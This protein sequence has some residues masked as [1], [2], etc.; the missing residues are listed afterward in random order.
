[1]NL[2]RTSL[3]LMLTALS[4]VAETR[5]RITGTKQKSENEILDLMGGRLAHVRANE[6]APSRADDA[7]F[8]VRQVLRKD[9]YTD[10]RVDWKI[11][12]RGEIVLTVHEG[13]RLS[14]GRVR[15][16]GVPPAEAEKLAKLYARPARKGHSFTS[17]A[18]PFREED[19]ETGLS[20]LRQELNAQGY[21]GGEAAVTNRTTDPASGAVDLTID[22]RPGPLYSIS[23]AKIVSRDGRGMPEAQAAAN[24]YAGKTATTGNLNAMRL[25]VEEVFV[26]SGYPDAEISMT[27]TLDAPRFVPEFFINLGKRVRLNRIDVEGLVRTNPKRIEARLKSLEGDW[28][29]EAAMNKRLRGFLAIGAFSTARLETREIAGDRIDA[30][31]HLEE[32]RAK[33]ISF[34]AGGDSYLG[35]LLRTTYTDRNLM[36]ELLGFSAGFEFSSRGVLGEARL[37]D[38]WF[39]GTDVAASARV[40]ALVYGREGYSTFETGL[41]G[42][43]TWEFGD[44]YKL[45][46]LVGFSFV[47]LTEDGLPVSELGETVYGQPRLRVTQTLDYRDSAVLPRNGWHLTAPLE[48]GSAMGDLSTSYVQAE[49]SGAWYHTFENDWQIV[50]GGAGGILMPSGDGVDLPINLRLFNGGARSVRSFPE[51][52]LG[53]TVEGY[54]TGGEG[55]WHANVELIRRLAGSLKAVGFVDA[56][57]LSREF[58][59]LSSG[60]VELAVGLGLRLDLPIGP[61]RLEY[62][63]N[64]TRDPGDPVGTLHFAIGVAF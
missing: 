63:Y 42:T 32:A 13:G 55:V 5:V 7:A 2:L 25:A 59:K 33:E 46:A 44:H 50:L 18:A 16:N 48:I 36:G 49:L 45:E 53:P 20:Y 10:V 58:D 24:P 41:E 56:G 38:P 52:E 21:W 3:I 61:V 1:M 9:G 19:A 14:L 54:P 26:S 43:G 8:L 39:M 57:S 37:V 12:G 34:A 51:R 30:T 15:V 29:D 28:Y 27:R 11:V 17:G 23:E 47:N 22:V 4:A 40:Y 60:D 64:L 62:G 31:L 35:A 6:A